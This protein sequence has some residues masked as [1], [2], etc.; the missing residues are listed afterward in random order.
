M[1]EQ[2]QGKNYFQKWIWDP[3]ITSSSVRE[4][5]PEDYLPNSMRTLRVRSDTLRIGPIRPW[6]SW[7]KWIGCVFLTWISSSFLH[8]MTYLSTL[9]VRRKPM[10]T[11][12]TKEHLAKFSRHEFWNWRVEFL[13]HTVSNVGNFEYSFNLSKPLSICRHQR[14]QQSFAKF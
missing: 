2:T 3:N 8:V 10:E 12:P 14:R 11:F 5:C 9:V 1:V 6:F 13:W 7:A 4:G